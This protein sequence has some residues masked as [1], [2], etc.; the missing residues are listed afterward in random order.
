MESKSYP[1]ECGLDGIFYRVE[2]NGKYVN[3]CFTDLTE[4]EQNEFLEKY[5]VPGLK[6]MC[7]LLAETVRTLGD[8]FDIM[9]VDSEEESY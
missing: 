5:D 1:T 9:R 4:D 3:R 2:R 7:L 8:Q 6:R